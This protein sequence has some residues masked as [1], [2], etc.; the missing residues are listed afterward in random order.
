MKPS[1]TPLRFIA[2][3]DILVDATYQRD[4][5]H[6][7]LKKMIARGWDEGLCG[8]IVLNHRP[9]GALAAIDGQHRIALA[10]HLGIQTIPAF[11]VRIPV[12][13]EA[14]LYVESQRARKRLTAWNLW[15]AGLLYDPETQAL[16]ALV[17]N[18]GFQIVGGGSQNMAIS[19]IVAMKQVYRRYGAESL[20]DALR[21]IKNAWNGSPGATKGIFLRGLCLFMH[22]WPEF[23]PKTF[24]RAMSKWDPDDILADATRRGAM[25]FSGGYQSVPVAR[26]LW[27][28]YNRGRNVTQGRLEDRL[29]E[30]KP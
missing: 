2:V 1:E 13:Q 17:E 22:T 29:P 12:E 11:V 28:I 4:I 7:S 5:D 27:A 10:Q 26:A 20:R 19:A 16:A 24:I 8:A 21:L 3:A 15:K 23:S 14:A 18:E 25:A 9:S 30:E 6:A